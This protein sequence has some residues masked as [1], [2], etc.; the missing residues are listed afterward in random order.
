MNGTFQLNVKVQRMLV[1]YAAV[2]L[3]RFRR[4]ESWSS[5]SR[6]A[7]SDAS[8]SFL[9]CSTR[10]DTVMGPQTPTQQMSNQGSKL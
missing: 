2:I 10:R 5:S 8:N 3:T 1:D 6:V 7:V 9:S 4:A